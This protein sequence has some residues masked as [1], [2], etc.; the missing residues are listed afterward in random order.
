[1]CSKLK[2]LV[3]WQFCARNSTQRTPYR[4]LDEVRRIEISN[5]VAEW[6]R[7][8]NTNRPNRLKV[9]LLDFSQLFASS[10]YTYQPPFNGTAVA[11]YLLILLPELSHIKCLYTLWVC[12]CVCLCV[13]F[14]YQCTHLRQSW[15]IPLVDI[16]NKGKNTRVAR[17]NKSL[18]ENWQKYTETWSALS[19]LSA[20]QTAKF[21]WYFQLELKIVC[22]DSMCSMLA[23][24]LSHWAPMLN[25]CV[26]VSFHLY[27][28]IKSIFCSLTV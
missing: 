8:K 24:M 5:E 23:S 14:E 7:G 11:Y 22:S 18:E 15:F 4:G 3:V 27:N 1:M 16:N 6:R 20:K 26:V 10:K 2:K 28:K 21:R 9:Y 25:V 17:K 13:Q 19:I 12:V